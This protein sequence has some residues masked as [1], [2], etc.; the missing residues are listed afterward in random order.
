[1]MSP[2]ERWMYRVIGLALITLFVVLAIG[3]IPSGG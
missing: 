1:M 2:G 3:H